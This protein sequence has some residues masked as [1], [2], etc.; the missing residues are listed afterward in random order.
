MKKLILPLGICLIMICSALA[1]PGAAQPIIRVPSAPVTMTAVHGN[2]CW[3]FLT[4]SGIPAGY[5]V[6][7]GIY[8]GWCVEVT[9]NM[10]LYVNH[11][12][13]LYSTYDPDLPFPSSNWDL[14]NYV[15]NNYVQSNDHR[16]SVQE[17]I[18][19]FINEDPLPLNDS[20]AMSLY[21]DAL[22]N[23][24]GF[25]PAFGEK[26][27]IL[28]N[29][30]SGGKDIQRTILEAT[31]REPV[32]LGDLVWNDKNSNGIQ[33]RGEPGLSGVTVRLLDD[34]N[35]IL[36]NATTDTNG[37]YEFSGQTEGN[38]SLQFVLK[39]SNYRFSLVDQGSDDLLDSDAN[40]VTGKTGVFTAF[41]TDTDDMSWDAGMYLV[42]EPGEPSDPGTP[43]PEPEAA[44]V[45]PTADGNAGTPYIA[46]LGEAILFNG[47]LSYDSDGTIVLYHWTFGDG[48][49]A[50]GVTVTHTYTSQGFYIVTL[51]V[52]DNKG[53]N[54]TFTTNASIRTPN[55]PPL[56]PTLTGSTTGTV[57]QAYLLRLVTSDINDDL[58]RYMISWGDN[59]ENNTIFY[60]SDVT[61]PIY[62]DWTTWGFYTIQAYAEDD[63]ENASSGISSLVVAVDV[64]SVG[65]HG[66]LIDTNSDGEYD[67]FY[68]NAT[69]T[70]NTVQRQQTGVYLID[71][72]GDGKFDL[73]YDPSTDASRTYPEGL[74]PTYTMLLVGLVVVII[75]VLII[76]LI[77]RRRMKKP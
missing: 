58:V 22:D 28:A 30:D 3:F 70:Q 23:G 66:Y 21:N 60:L 40:R 26:I 57:D 53:A 9:K 35:T 2:I 33:E 42:E 29:V 63:W 45:P 50:D 65:T 61:V 19:F 38:Y 67:A 16:Q 74:D 10:T 62:H 37:Y 39:S 7:N 48:T 52:T 27:A 36:D 13:L 25:I 56:A 12:V 77:M 55:Q 47:S 43:V 51:K 34:N 15:I 20:Y 18:W 72:S 75:I 4:L 69:G 76:G 24:E 68:S 54:D 5:D 17:V 73:Q 14:V 46:L 64:R 44:N 11:K 71:T 1:I 32:Q 31:L 41:V 49:N 59:T 6:T 8:N